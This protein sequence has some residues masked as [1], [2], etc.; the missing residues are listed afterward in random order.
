MEST[1]ATQFTVT[2][3]TSEFNCDV[4]GYTIRLRHIPSGEMHFYFASGGD[5]NY[6]V[7]DGLRAGFTYQV[8]VAGL[9]I[10]REL[11]EVGFINVTTGNDACL[12]RLMH[13]SVNSQ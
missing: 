8:T 7:A 6:Y 11:P 2:W 3:V 13:I 5:T 12:D 1:S 10:D 4:Y 9:Q